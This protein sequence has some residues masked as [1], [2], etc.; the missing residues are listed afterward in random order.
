MDRCK[1]VH[2]WAYEF[3]SCLFLVMFLLSFF[4]L[5]GFYMAHKVNPFLNRTNTCLRPAKDRVLFKKLPDL[6]WLITLSLSG[7]V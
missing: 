1:L 2:T 6:C 7:L 4:A 3:F 5:N